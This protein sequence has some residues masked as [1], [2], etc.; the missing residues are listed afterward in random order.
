[1]NQERR[2]YFRING[3][4]AVDYKIISEDEMKH[5]RLPTQFQVSPFFLLL[6]QL[7]AYNNDSSYH[8]RKIAQKEPA[9]ATYLELMNDKIDAIAHAVAKSDVDFDNLSSQEINLSEGGMSFNSQAAIELNSYLALKVVFEETHSGLLLYGQ[10]LYCSEKG[11]DGQYK[12]GIEFSDMPESSRMI[13][14]R[15]ILNSQTRAR[16]QTHE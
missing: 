5:G 16:Q 8:L 1:M 14:A 10:V 12:I 13:V 3:K 9:I 4:V 11:D 2:Q 7:Q 6:N 15:Y